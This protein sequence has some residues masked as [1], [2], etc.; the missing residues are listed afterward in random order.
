MES[1]TFYVPLPEQALFDETFKILNGVARAPVTSITS[2]AV[3][4]TDTLIWYDHWEDGYEAD[5]TN[6]KSSTTQIWGDGDA[7][8]GCAPIAIICTNANDKLVAGDAILLENS[9]PLPRNK[10]TIRFH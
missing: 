3:S 2:I 9:V 6:P 8:N 4:T 1:Q 10:N 7:S 5:I